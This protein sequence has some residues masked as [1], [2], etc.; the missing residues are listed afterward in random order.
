MK[1]GK[2]IGYLLIAGAIGVLLPYTMLT[3]I[4]DYPGI[5][6]EESST[7]LTRF[8]HGGSS[9]IFTWFAFAILGLPLLVAY[10][11]IGQV[12]NAKMPQLKWATTMGIISVIVQIIALL[13]WVFVVPVLATEYVNTSSPSKQE[14]IETS[15]K[16]IHQFA[17]VLLGEHM[18]QLFTIIWTIVISAAMHK[19]QLIPKWLLWWGFIT[20]FIYFLAQAEL[21]ATV[22]A[23]FPVIEMAGFLGSTLW[24]LWIILAGFQFIKGGKG[25][26]NHYII[27]KT[28]SRKNF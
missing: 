9:L 20:S 16:M 22:I 15:F 25:I 1:T 14:A 13:R 23:G 28:L 27:G 24:L 19:L 12:V 21:L 18:G 3:F 6:R 26:N 7:I 11:L 8:H 5:L 17:G 4:F 2:I 10:S